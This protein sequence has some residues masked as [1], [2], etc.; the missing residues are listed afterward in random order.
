MVNFNF[1]HLFI[2]HDF[3]VRFYLL[4]KISDIKNKT[5]LDVGG[6]IGI[7]CSEMN[8]TNL[9]INLDTSLNDLRICKNESDPEIQN[10]CAS[11]TRL[12]FKD[13][14]FDYVISANILEVTKQLDLENGDY[15]L[16][17]NVYTYPTL[18]KSL[19]EISRVIHSKGKLFLTTPNNAYYQTK[20][21]TY[22]ELKHAL[23]RYFSNTRIFFYN[24]YAKLS[25]N[26]KFNLANVIPKFSSK[27]QDSNTIMSSLVKE[28]SSKNYSV[29]FFAVCESKS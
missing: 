5:I 25:K 22:N 9:R 12:P 8:N 24:T 21:L 15:D 10:V 18:E 20:K 2:I 4:S 6:G 19:E 17:N 1:I 27:F 29:S 3:D 23:E 14:V 16:E 13:E 26:R 28:K 7:I 11:M